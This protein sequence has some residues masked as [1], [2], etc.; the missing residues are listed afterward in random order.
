MFLMNKIFYMH[1]INML[2]LIGIVDQINDNSIIVEYEEN[3][4]LLY[5]TVSLTQSACTPTE[6]MTVHFFKDYKIIK[7]EGDSQ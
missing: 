3:G 1:M 4:K 5:S 6:G 2:L 7:C